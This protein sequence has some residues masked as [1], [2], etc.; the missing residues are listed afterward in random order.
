MCLDYFH[1]IL[2]I[3]L[4]LHS[5]N[6]WIM[7]TCTHICTE[8]HPN[9]SILC[10]QQSLWENITHLF[11]VYFGFPCPP[12]ALSI[13]ESS[14]K[15]SRAGKIS[16]PLPFVHC[17]SNEPSRREDISY[18]TQSHPRHQQRG[19]LL[20]WQCHFL[21]GCL[22]Y[23]LT[24]LCS[25]EICQ[26]IPE[27]DWEMTREQRIHIKDEKYILNLKPVISTVIFIN[28][29]LQRRCIFVQVY[30]TPSIIGL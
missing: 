14:A 9:V 19:K 26:L 8:L 6:V 23:S 27:R 7:D 29:T 12:P 11:L 3:Y 10:L 1:Y 25:S 28:W 20:S 16:P 13:L 24:F 4:A 2:R 22:V 17:N 30:T 5:C 18:C 21:P 15:C